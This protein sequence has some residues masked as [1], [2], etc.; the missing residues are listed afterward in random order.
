MYRV[1]YRWILDWL[2]YKLD[3]WVLNTDCSD[4]GG[5]CLVQV[6]V[7][8]VPPY[9]PKTCCKFLSQ[10]HNS[11]GWVNP[12]SKVSSD[13]SKKFLSS[14]YRILKK[15]SNEILYCLPAS[16]THSVKRS[17]QQAT[18]TVLR[19]FGGEQTFCIF[20]TIQCF[21]ILSEVLISRHTIVYRA[22]K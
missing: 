11:I 2:L 10:Q 1:I 13:Q 12:S 21:R 4:Y 20:I 7:T 3:R 15:L 22:A 5:D 8:Q 18:A 16:L 9:N 14:C 19:K 17:G 6:T